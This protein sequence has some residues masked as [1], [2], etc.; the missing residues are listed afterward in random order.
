M[1]P[2]GLARC[3]LPSARHAFPETRGTVGHLGSLAFALSFGSSAPLPC[4]TPLLPLGVVG[5][6]TTLL[7]FEEGD[8]VFSMKQL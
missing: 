2:G 3:E 1:P 7:E 5:L 8:V 6:A 4:K